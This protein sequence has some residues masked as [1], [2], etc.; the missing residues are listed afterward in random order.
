M[1][2]PDT[3]TQY[4]S[5]LFPTTAAQRKVAHPYV[6]QIDALHA[7]KAPLVTKVENY[8]GFYAAEGYHQNVLTLHPTHPYI[9]IN[10]MPEADNLTRFAPAQHR[11]D[12]VLAANAN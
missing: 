11:A 12:A 1:A 9:A 7:F 2:G 10:D 6:K 5:A 3:V 8:S 4:R